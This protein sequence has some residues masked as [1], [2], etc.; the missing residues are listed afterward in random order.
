MD[1]LFDWFAG[2]VELYPA[3]GLF[4]ISLQDLLSCFQHMDY[5]FDWFAGL[6]ELYPAH[7]LFLD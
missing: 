6:V 2:V 5:L 3:H 1:Y 7:G 4:L